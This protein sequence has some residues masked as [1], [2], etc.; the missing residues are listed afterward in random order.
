VREVY[1]V[2]YLPNVSQEIED[3]S[4]VGGIP[5]M[6]SSIPVPRCR[7]CNHVM[8]FFF[9]MKLPLKG[10]WEGKVLCFFLC[11][12]CDDLHK[13]LP[14]RPKTYNVES[15][16]M[17]DG[18]LE[19]HELNFKTVVF[20]A[21]AVTSQRFDIEQR[22]AFQKIT[23][24][25]LTKWKKYPFDTIGGKPNWRYNE[26]PE[27]YE[28]HPFELLLQIVTEHRFPTIPGAPP[29][30]VLGGRNNQDFYEIFWG[31]P[32]YFMGTVTTNGPKIYVI[33]HR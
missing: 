12:S 4:F 11:T 31:T 20:D 8:T 33:T 1:R 27:A 17:P 7:L 3:D 5:K 10:A 16:S 18:Y 9:Q 14:G 2:N 13:G 6:P 30:L 29:Q 19:D 24:E 15:F 21:D 26:M 25:K 28:G 23:F 32:T 22:L